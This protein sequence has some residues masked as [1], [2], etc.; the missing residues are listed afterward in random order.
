M[1]NGVVDTGGALP[2][3]EERSASVGLIGE[4]DMSA[5]DIYSKS[6]L[7]VEEVSNR[8]LKLSPRVRTML[9]LVDGQVP[10]FVLKEE[11]QKV[12]AAP[13]FLEQLQTMGLIVKIG[14]VAGQSKEEIKAPAT[15]EFTRFRLAQD[16][17]NVSVVNSLGIKSF[18]FTLKLERAGTILDLHQLVEPYRE[19]ITKGSGKEEAEVLTQRLQGMLGDSRP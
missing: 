15:D 17:M 6:Q 9:I 7:G 8:K 10:L 4:V 16:F 5:G 18:F 19:A 11:A 13:D 14:N 12:G 3:S 1:S 2:N